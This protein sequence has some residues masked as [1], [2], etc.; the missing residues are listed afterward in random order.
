MP[1]NQTTAL[2]KKIIQGHSKDDTIGNS[3]LYK[4][5]KIKHEEGTPEYKKYV[6]V[7]KT[8]ARRTAKKYAYRVNTKYYT[9][10]REDALSKG[11]AYFKDWFFKNHIYNP[12]ERRFEPIAIWRKTEI[13]TDVNSD[14]EVEWNAGYA[15]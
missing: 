15:F 7:R 6:D 10:A 12:Y 11:K 4:S 9:M 14:I 5:F 1:N 8:N 13:N 2:F 3:Y